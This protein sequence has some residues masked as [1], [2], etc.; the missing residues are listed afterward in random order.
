MKKI[1]IYLATALFTLG[2]FSCNDFLEKEVDLSLSDEQVF[3]SFE[4]TRGF[5][6]NIYTY[7]PDPFAGYNNGQFL[8]ASRDCMT[9]NSLSFW[10]VHYYHSVLTD[11]YSATDHPFAKDFWPK[12]FKGIRA[13]NQF[14]KN[15]RQSVI[16][17]S[18]KVGDDNH[19]YDRNIAEARLLRAIFHF[20]IAC[21]FGDVPII[22][23]DENGQPI[24]FDPSD[25]E[26]MNRARTSCADALKWIADE[27]DA[28]KDKLPYRYSNEDE[29][30]GRVNGAAAYALK[31]RAL[32]YR[33]SALH[34][35]SNDVSYW[36]EAATAAQDLI[37]KNNSQSKRY[38]LYTTSD[39]N[40]NKNYYEC[41]VTTPYYN[42]EYILTRSVW[43][44]Y[45]IELFLAPC[46]FSGTA[47][48]T[49]RTNPTQNLVDSYETINGLPIDQDP[50]YNDQN[51]YAN[52]DPR[53]EQTILRNGSIWGDPLQEEQRPVDVSYP[54]G[55]DY[56]ALHG[57]TL[58]G[59]Y[60]KKFL[61][62]MSFKSP[63]SYNHACPIFR[64]GE[65]LL[66]AAEA[67]NE[68]YGPDQAY[69]YVNQVRARVGMP[70]YKGMTKDQLRERI[71]NERRIELCFEDHRFFDER[72]WKLF[73]NQTT[74]NEKNLPRYKQVYNIYGVT[75]TPDAS[76]VYTYGPAQKHPTRAFSSPKNYYFPLP[77]AEVK[78]A[79][80]LKQNPGWDLSSGSK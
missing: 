42:D 23:D 28:V 80:N 5:L 73:D 46:G 32:L 44:T 16:G 45:E 58:T 50:T 79:P 70:P 41:F 55:Q 43:S 12:D 36:K 6:A 68:A 20:D 65:V 52:R 37:T 4:N 51:P 13:A 26:T 38:K 19:L 10:D 18:E 40:P 67:I 53:L 25:T 7:L 64:Y 39:N 76:T 1:K 9:D 24:V 8:A 35:P 60:T 78:K 75:V 72:R 47:N 22:G 77:D 11:S 69:Q 54:D 74:S 21:W 31:S 49:G 2:L 62:N 57:G 56:Q 3:S 71:R 30:W 61:N 17:N 34:N 63:S 15:A 59:Y 33:A 14:M 27:C 29:N 48:S 66:N